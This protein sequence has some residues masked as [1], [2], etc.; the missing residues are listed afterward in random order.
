MPWQISRVCLL[1]R[2]L[3]VG[4]IDRSHVLG[5][6]A[7]IM[8]FA[9]IQFDSREDCAEAIHKLSARGRV[10]MLRGDYFIV[11]EPAIQ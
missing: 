3:M 8:K 10:V 4:L 1:M 5:Y 9:K 6:Y 7:V 2:M 11:P